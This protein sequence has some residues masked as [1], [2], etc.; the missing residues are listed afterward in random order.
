[1]LS[2]NN[3]TQ[4]IT[5]PT[6]NTG[7]QDVA[8]IQVKPN[9]AVGGQVS[10]VLFTPDGTSSTEAVAG[11]VI[12][13]VSMAPDGTLG[14]AVYATVTANGGV[15]A[16]GTLTWAVNVSGTLPIITAAW[17]PDDST[18][19]AVLAFAVNY[20]GGTNGGGIFP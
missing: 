5:I 6:G 17:A 14:G 18:S 9:N 16:M 4:S 15:D 3:F 20:Y 1:M 12:F 19:D 13:C 8:T 7:A 11:L 2:G 10:Y